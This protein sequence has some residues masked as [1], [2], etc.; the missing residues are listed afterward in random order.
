MCLSV[1]QMIL[2]GGFV[3]IGCVVAFGLIIAVF[4]QEYD[5]FVLRHHEPGEEDDSE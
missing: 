5:A 1:W 4:M 2:T 3:L